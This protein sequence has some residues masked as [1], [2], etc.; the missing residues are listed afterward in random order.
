MAYSY[1][2]EAPDT[3]KLVLAVVVALLLTVSGYEYQLLQGKED[4]VQELTGQLSVTQQVLD[5]TKEALR[6]TQADN[7]QLRADV[8][9]RDDTIATM[10]RQLGLAER[11]IRDLTPITK[12]F[13]AVGVDQ[14]GNG[15]IIPLEVKIVGGNGSISVN[16]KNV[17]LQAGVQ[18]SIRTAADVAED[19]TN[20]D[21]GSRDVTVSFINEDDAIVS[22]DGTSAGGAITATIIAAI[23]NK[24][25]R[26]DVLMTGTIN[27]D[28][29]IGPVGS[30]S[31]KAQAAK[32]YGASIF[33][34]PSGQRV[35]LSGLTVAE[36][37][38]IQD[39]ASKLLR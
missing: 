7:D 1:Y 19:Y 17:D 5:V 16:I 13:A 28:G 29:S 18:S 31:T 8:S 27:S 35:S 30:V 9:A 39:V 3:L 33:L 37:D 6:T 34:V 36:V 26:N 11:Q 2:K 15:V 22:V 25:M 23:Q 10:G 21:L 32:D 24:T 14:S 20:R 38:D 12:R 4:Q